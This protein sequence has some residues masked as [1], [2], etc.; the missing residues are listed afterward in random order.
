MAPIPQF[1]GNINVTICV[2]RYALVAYYAYF[3]AS[4]IDRRLLICVKSTIF[5]YAGE[6]VG[7]Q[8]CY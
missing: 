7:C 8:Q 4:I 6:N 5:K 3:Y 1:S 2:D